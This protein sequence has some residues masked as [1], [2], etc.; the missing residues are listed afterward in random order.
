MTNQNPD[1]Y[2]LTVKPAFEQRY[3]QILGS[4]YEEFMEISRT[5]PRKSLR[6]NTLKSSVDEIKWRLQGKFSLSQIP[7]CKEGFWITGERR[8]VGNLIE[9]ALG[10]IYVQE[11]ASMLPVEALMPGLGEQVLDMCAAPGSKSSQIAAKMDNSGVLIANDHSA[12]R[13]KALSVNLQRSGVL[14]AIITEMEGSQLR[15]IQFDRVL[16]D[17]PCSATGT[18]RKSPGTLQ[19]WNPLM[20]TRLTATQKRLLQAGFD[21]LRP[22]GTLVY[23]TCTLE[24]EE[25]EGVMSWLLESNANAEAVDISL[26][27]KRSEPIRSFA[28]VDFNP[29]VSKALRI[30]P[31]D[32][33]TD[34]FFVAK[35]RKK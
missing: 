7:W 34:G 6:A 15:K 19:M 29:G 35:I 25:D 14:N 17:A 24:P 26:E 16:V 13:L 3:R 22:G 2:K 9:H 4:R 31:M 1:A 32:N 21:S 20:V 8:D 12:L 11:A 10:Y 28:G 33:D 23:S 5:Y 18:L 27:I 30:Y